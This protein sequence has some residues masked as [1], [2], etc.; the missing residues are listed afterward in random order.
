MESGVQLGLGEGPIKKVGPM[1]QPR[2]TIDT[3]SRT[4]VLTH[5]HGAFRPTLLWSAMGDLI[6]H[7]GGVVSH[8]AR[9]IRGTIFC[10]EKEHYK[11]D[12]LEYQ[13]QK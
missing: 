8:R 12:L 3:V 4:M 11:K 1:S 10:R 2:Y 9:K 5:V 13:E 7:V 6:P